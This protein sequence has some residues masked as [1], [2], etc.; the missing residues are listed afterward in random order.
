VIN[1]GLSAYFH[2]W[3]KPDRLYLPGFL[4]LPHRC[5]SLI[6]KVPLIYTHQRG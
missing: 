4:S 2:G 6:V 3:K 1:C 5:F